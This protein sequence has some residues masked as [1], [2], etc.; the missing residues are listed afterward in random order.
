V[1]SEN[2]GIIDYVGDKVVPSPL[3]RSIYEAR[4]KNADSLLSDL[5]IEILRPEILGDSS[6]CGAIIEALRLMIKTSE[7][8]L[9]CPISPDLASISQITALKILQVLKLAQADAEFIRI[10]SLSYSIL[11]E[12]INMGPI[13]RLTE[14]QLW[15]KEHKRNL[16]A[17]ETE[18][19]VVEYE[20][21][22][23]IDQGAPHLTDLVQR[24][25]E[26]DVGAG[27]DIQ[28]YEADG[29]PRYIEVKSST[30]Q[31]VQ[32][33]WSASEM[34]FARIKSSQYYIYFVPKCQDLPRVFPGL[35]ILKNPLSSYPAHLSSEPE[36][37]FVSLITPRSQFSQET[38]CGI[39][40]VT[41]GG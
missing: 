28:S 12:L 37:Y 1:I 16:L 22:R 20:K 38:I 30:R 3:G 2:I 10:P 17:R 15:E 33:Y 7:G 5:Q 41:I 8:S 13:P 26:F 19:W 39:S 31:K 32:F 11:G 14:Q 34:D 24:V 40:V 36:D 6:I 4:S 9:F 18:L 27:Y 21:H 25:S 29:T 35:T 23:L